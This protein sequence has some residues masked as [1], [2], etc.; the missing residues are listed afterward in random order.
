ML[1]IVGERPGLALLCSGAAG[2]SSPDH[3]PEQTPRCPACGRRFVMIAMHAGCD[4]TGQRTRRQLWGCPVG[5]A[6]VYRAG[7]R[8][9]AVDTYEETDDE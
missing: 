5:H 7:G 3:D 9:G 4:A 6:A 2:S 1:G 8:F